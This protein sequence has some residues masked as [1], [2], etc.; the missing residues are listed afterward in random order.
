MVKTARPVHRVNSKTVSGFPDVSNVRLMRIHSKA[1]KLVNATLGIWGPTA[2]H[3]SHAL[4]ES[5]RQEQAILPVLTVLLTRIHSKA[6]KLV[7]ATLGIRGLTAAHAS[8][9]LQESIRQ[10]QA[11]LPVLTVP[12]IRL[13]SLTA[14][15]VLAMR[16]T[17]VW[18]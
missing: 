3:A 7:N 10:K 1:V 17:R 2:A 12:K 5:I 8:Y 15:T 9:A 18:V 6:V 4:Q 11:M 16:A 14:A 13:L